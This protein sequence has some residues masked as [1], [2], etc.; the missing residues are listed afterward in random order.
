MAGG[1]SGYLIKVGGSLGVELPLKYMKL[2]GY[3][4][5][6]NQRMESSAKRSVTG[7]LNRTTVDHTATKIEF[8]TPIVTDKDVHAIMGLFGN[9][10]TSVAERKLDLE[11]YD[12]ETGT[13]KT[14][15]FYMPDIKFEIDH[16]DGNVI[17]YKNI[18]FKFIE[19]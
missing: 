15:T 7:Y 6:P 8:A 2:E 10:W 3:D 11:Y 1:F 17:Y 13:Y 14:G 18:T 4:I 9:A 16:I 12:M 5:T 19:Y